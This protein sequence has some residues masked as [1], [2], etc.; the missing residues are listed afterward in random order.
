[1]QGKVVL[2]SAA[3][4]FFLFFFVFVFVLFFFVVVVTKPQLK[5]P[6]LDVS[7]PNMCGVGHF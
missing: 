4:L 1:M 2:H 3:V 7:L 5:A 6:P